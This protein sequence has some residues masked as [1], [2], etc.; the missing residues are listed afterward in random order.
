MTAQSRAVPAVTATVV[1]SERSDREPFAVVDWALFGAIG[2]IW[3][4]SFLFI[5]LGLEAFH[6]G[7]ITW[8]RVGL[9][10]VA[11]MAVPAARK[12]IERRDLGRLFQ[13]S[14]IW[15]GIP[16]TLFP[17]AEEHINSAVTGLLN[18]ATP[19]FAA[20]FGALFFGRVIGRAQRWGIL[21][22]FAGIALISVGSSAEGGT[23]IVGVLMVI[24]ATLCYGYA[25]NLAGP[26]QRKYGS[27]AVM[28]QMLLLG[29]LWTMPFGIVGLTRSGF[30]WKASIAVAVLGVV[31]T[32]FAFTLMGTLV[33]R[34]GG[35]R[36]SLITYLM[37]IVSLALGA[38]FLSER[39]AAVAL[40]GIAIILGG[41]ALASRREH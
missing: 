16:F 5:K 21:L 4:A 6:P 18:G 7:L 32:G 3:G 9:G 33:G 36:A 11:L 38:I 25:T 30:A 2:I 19:F 27:V 8:A 12:R 39:V 31:G 26:L 15:V 29:A 20:I 1:A 40:V 10:A 41:A 37:P 14:I 13:L 35:P 17:L 24:A 22:G 23:A 34:V 28:G